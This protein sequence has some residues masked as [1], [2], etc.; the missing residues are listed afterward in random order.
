M[1]KQKVI[2]RP[3]TSNENED[4]LLSELHPVLRR[5]LMARNIKTMT[6]LDYSLKNLL[7]YTQLYGIE[8]AVNLLYQKL[9]TQARV[10]IIA[11]YDAD[12]ATSCAVAIK[13]LQQMGLQQVGYLVPNREK[14]G[15]GLTPEIVEFALKDSLI[16]QSKLKLAPNLLI[17]V[18]NGIS[19]IAGVQLAKQHGLQVLITDH[20]LPAKQLPNADAIVNPNQSA[21]HFPSKHLAGVGVIFY[22]LLALRARLRQCGWFT[23][24][25]IPDPPLAELL[26][27]VALGTVADVVSL[28]YNNRILVEQGLR[29]MRADHCCAGI[30]ALIHIAKREQ[31]H[32]LAEDLA[33]FLAPRLNAAGRMDDMSYGIACLISE[34][35]AEAL[36]YAQILDHFNHERRFVEAEMQQEALAVINGEIFNDHQV[37]PT[38]LCLFDKHWHQGVVGIVAGRIK[39]RLHRPVI[40]FAQADELTLKGSARS[41]PGVHIRDVLES[42]ATQYPDLIS[43]FGGHAMAA[44]LSLPITQLQRFQHIF[45]ET[46]SQYLSAEDLQG[47]IMTD[48]ELTADDFN[49]DLAE[50]LRTLTPWGQNFPEPIFEGLFELMEYQVLKE[51]HLRM[52]VRPLESD[53][54]LN[55]IAFNADL[56]FCHARKIYLVYKLDINYFRGTK[57]LQLVIKHIIAQTE[58]LQISS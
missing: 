7:P 5:V 48:G 17:T 12:G 34:N 6:A 39:D 9:T 53:L 20:H 15:Y 18:D 27:L 33:F 31:P 16:A 24:Q 52:K 44:G 10:L 50:Q 46:V 55:A 29:R 21:D 14:H 32:L 8:T 19:S 56:S 13:G 3:L 57:N 47:V 22:V 36:E 49:L 11:D 38:G 37:L 4:E 58:L 42:I 54:F 1:K 2:R 26:D 28:D 43:K 35:E 25:N 30:R 51:K 41:V 45:N 23:A 40:V